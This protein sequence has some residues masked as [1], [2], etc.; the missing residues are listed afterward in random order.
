MA[1]TSRQGLAGGGKLLGFSSPYCVVASAAGIFFIWGKSSVHLIPSSLLMG[2]GQLHQEILL[3]RVSQGVSRMNIW[4]RSVGRPADR[5]ER[6]IMSPPLGYFGHTAP[7][8]MHLATIIR[9]F[10]PAFSSLSPPE[11]FGALHPQY[12]YLPG[13]HACMHA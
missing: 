12:Y 10:R 6:L 4:P 2:K 5:Y 13:L 9:P 3:R 11:D 1:S 7:L 8:R